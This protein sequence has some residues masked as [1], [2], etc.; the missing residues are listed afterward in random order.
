MSKEPGLP[1]H[2][3]PVVRDTCL[4]LQVR[5]AARAMA[6]HFDEAL[7]PVGLTNGQ[8]SLL[9]ALNRPGA[10]GMAEVASVLAM[11]RTTLTANLKPL[12]RRGLIEVETDPGDRRMRRMSLTGEGRS[13]LAGAYPLWQA[14]QAEAEGMLAGSDPHR[15]RS[16]LAVLGA[17]GRGTG[18]VRRSTRAR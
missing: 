16:D 1:F 3:T 13:L 4:C 5:R 14:A 2:L 12:Q 11:D 9:M 6:R 17:G 7:R 15:L 8:F 10:A 18:G